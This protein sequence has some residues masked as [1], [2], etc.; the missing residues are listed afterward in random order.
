MRTVTRPAAMRPYWR[1]GPAGVPSAAVDCCR[2]DI[3]VEPVRRQR[4]LVLAS[5]SPYRRALLER[6]E[7]PFETISPRVSEEVRPGETAQELVRRLAEAKARAVI[8][9]APSALI[10]GCDQVA[11]MDGMIVGKPGTMERATSQL[12]RASGRTVVFQTGL[13]LLDGISG[14]A[15][16]HVEPFQVTFRTL[17]SE[18]I[19]DYLRRERPLDC[20][21]AFRSEGLGIALFSELIGSD[22]NTLVGLPLI[23]LISMLE[24]AGIRVLGRS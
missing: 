8:P 23:R 24:Q 5:G 16:V 11:T 7:L 19:A 10:I 9:L 2:E 6:L 13:C 15:R 18:Q 1:Q 20:A 12:E 4:R 3:D 14:R 21:G 17:S 22:P